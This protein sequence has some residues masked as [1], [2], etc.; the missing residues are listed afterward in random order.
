VYQ[1]SLLR[2][3]KSGPRSVLKLDPT[4]RE[5]CKKSSLAY[6]TS[7]N[8]VDVEPQV[9]SLRL[10]LNMKFS[11]IHDPKG[12]C[13]DVSAVGH[14]GNGEIEVSLSSPRQLDDVMYLIRQSFEKH[15]EEDV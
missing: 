1:V 8:F 7:T 13:Q 6:K 14:R 12:L 5:E 2:P 3:L 11:E 10:F 15:W 9:K 4:V